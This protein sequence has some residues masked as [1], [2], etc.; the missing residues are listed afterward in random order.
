MVS[1][2]FL[3]THKTL[4]VLQV[5]TGRRKRL[6]SWVYFYCAFWGGSSG[7]GQSCDLIH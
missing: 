1:Q 7:D 5:Q 2:V 4:I 6:Y 3:K